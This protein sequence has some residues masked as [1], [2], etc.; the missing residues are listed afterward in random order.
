MSDRSPETLKNEF[1]ESQHIAVL[2][3]VN[4]SGEPR[5]CTIFFVAASDGG[6]L[7]KSRSNS[8]HMVN[9]ASQS[10][11]AL[12]IYDA[13]SSYGSKR[14][15]QIVGTVS[16]ITDETKMRDAVERYSAAF[17]G[18]RER[19]ASLAELIADDASS[20]MYRFEI[21]SWKHTDT[22]RGLEPLKYDN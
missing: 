18:A 11:A 2:A 17:D 14:G 10:G 4:T 9:V 8:E 19:F 7:F 5:A 16:R 1:L 6:L 12:A 20:T 15:M 21:R 13:G 3:T 22:D